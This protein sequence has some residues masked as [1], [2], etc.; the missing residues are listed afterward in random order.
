MLHGVSGVCCL[1]V[2]IIVIEQVAVR[3]LIAIAP[4]RRTIS[5]QLNCISSSRVTVSV[6][7]L[8]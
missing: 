4:P 8:L 5:S 1:E 2:I 7:C 3:L 6:H